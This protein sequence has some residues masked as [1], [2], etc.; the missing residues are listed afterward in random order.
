MVN[1][2]L[3]SRVL[4]MH[5]HRSCSLHQSGKIVVDGTGL[6]SDSSASIIV[7]AIIKDIIVTRPWNRRRRLAAWPDISLLR[8]D[9]EFSSVFRITTYW[10]QGDNDSRQAKKPSCWT[11]QTVWYVCTGAVDAVPES[12]HR[13]IRRSRW[14]IGDAAAC[15]SDNKISYKITLQ[16][17]HYE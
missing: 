14:L 3:L 11:H 8:A 6:F 9:Y 7:W 13:P 10:L 12:L 16:T 5:L 1:F 15:T 4:P 17:L 2:V